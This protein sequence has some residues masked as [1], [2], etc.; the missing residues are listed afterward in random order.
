[1]SPTIVAGRWQQFGKGSRGSTCLLFNIQP[2]CFFASEIPSTCILIGK[3]MEPEFLRY[4]RVQDKL[5][6]LRPMALQS[7]L[8]T[9]IS[10]SHATAI[11]GDVET[12]KRPGGS[13]TAVA[14]NESGHEQELRRSF[15]LPSLAGVGLVVGA[16][17][18]VAGGS[19]GAAAANGGP[20]GVL[21]EFAAV[22]LAYFPVAASV[23]ELASAVPSSAGVY[24]WA[25]L[26]PGAARWG[27]PVGFFAG[28][29]NFLAWCLGAASMAAILGN[30]VVQ[31][32]ALNHPAFA[33]R[34]WHVFVVYVLA[35]WVA[36]AVVCLGNAAM[37]HLNK[38]GI[39]CI[40]AGFIITVAV[41]AAAPARHASSAFVWTAWRRADDGLGYPDGFIFAAG[42]LN[43][44]YSIG[45]VDATTHL[46]EEIPRPRRNLPR[47]IALQVGLGAATGFAYLVAVM[48]AVAD[49]PAVLA[50]PYPVA[51]IYR[52]ATGSAAGASALLALSLACVALTVA[53]LYI[54]CGRALWALAR[55]GATPFPRH[56]GRV[57]PRLGMP[58]WATVATAAL[59]TALGCIYVGSE[60]AF[61]AFISAFLQLSTSSFLAAILPNLLT[62]RKNIRYGPFHMRG[63]TGFVVNGLAC[64]YMLVW[65]VIFSFPYALPTT[66]QTMNYSCLIWG[67]LTVFVAAWWVFK[68][69]HG[70][71]GPARIHEAYT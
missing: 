21:Y 4:I 51:E 37:P 39:V 34:A 16:V 23:A 58:A 33:P 41:V 20:P 11:T 13:D 26:T 42:M 24:A 44:A 7:A 71:E 38:L 67:G 66:P 22:S 30:C 9:L 17:W 60:T 35:T 54:T 64:A 28:C 25:S 5:T 40:L 12:P 10:A 55:D 8:R 46:A 36:C 49:Y 56:L 50:S 68:A 19:L 1:M 15:S 57:D 69:R 27:R 18:P 6:P 31:M 14:V 61:N 59:V 47:A 65:F 52:Q 29:W 43:G 53:G 32:Y 48:Y 62:G 2:L 45:P 63:W 3:P 70:Y